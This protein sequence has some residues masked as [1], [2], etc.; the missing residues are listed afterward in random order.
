MNFLSKNKKYIIFLNIIT[1]LIL[2]G[3]SLS[4]TK[5]VRLDL[6][7]EQVCLYSNLDRPVL[8]LGTGWTEKNFNFG[9]G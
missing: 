8:N 2:I 6:Q 3:L 7:L 1:I 9:I 5:S 4:L